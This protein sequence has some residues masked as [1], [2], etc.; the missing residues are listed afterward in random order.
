MEELLMFYIE[1][2]CGSRLTL[3]GVTELSGSD[4]RGWSWKVPDFLLMSPEEGLFIKQKNKIRG[5]GVCS[6]K[7]FW[8]VF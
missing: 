4:H 5:R 7:A 2:A 1:L 8:P 6:P 3:N